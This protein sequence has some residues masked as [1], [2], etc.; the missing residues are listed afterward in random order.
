VDVHLDD[1]GAVE[2]GK[3]A[4]LVPLDADPLEDIHNTKAIAAVFLGGKL[5]DHAALS[6]WLKAAEA[7]ASTR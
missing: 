5:F 4:D 2:P 1:Y 3:L 7:E 6:G